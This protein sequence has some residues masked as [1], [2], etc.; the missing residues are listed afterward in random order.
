MHIIHPTQPSS[1]IYKHKTDQF[2]IPGGFW[3]NPDEPST[4]RRTGVPPSAPPVSQ[5][6]SW[7][8]NIGSQTTPSLINYIKSACTATLFFERIIYVSRY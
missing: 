5:P 2:Y 7:P 1:H 4:E 8:T 3:P 6:Q